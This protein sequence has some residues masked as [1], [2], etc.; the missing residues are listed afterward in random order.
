MPEMVSEQAGYIDGAPVT[1]SACSTRS[2][3]VFALG[4]CGEKLT[5]RIEALEGTAR[6]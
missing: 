4:K 1:T 3:L 6:Q 5:A 2:P